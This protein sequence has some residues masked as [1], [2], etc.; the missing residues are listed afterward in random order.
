MTRRPET[1]IDD[2][3]R[4]AYFCVKATQRFSAASPAGDDHQA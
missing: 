4:P 3:V 1:R 2:A